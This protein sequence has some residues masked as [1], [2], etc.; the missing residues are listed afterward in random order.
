MQT[1]RLSEVSTAVER[2][3]DTAGNMTQVRSPALTPLVC[4]DSDDNVDA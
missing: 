3:Y 1:D 4:T 2:T